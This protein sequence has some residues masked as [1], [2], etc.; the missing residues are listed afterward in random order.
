MKIVDT[1]CDAINSVQ[2]IIIIEDTDCDAINSGQMIIILFF[3]FIC[4]T[5]YY[6]VKLSLSNIRIL[7]W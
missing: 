7:I 3:I 4:P 5:V 1:D 6:C 2:M